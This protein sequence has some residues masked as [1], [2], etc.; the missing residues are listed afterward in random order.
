[1]NNWV[2]E[3]EFIDGTGKYFNSRK[4]ELLLSREG[5]SG[6]ITKAKLRMIDLPTLSIDLFCF[7]EP[8][9]LLGQVR[10]LRKDREVYFLEFID[11]RTAAELGMGQT[12]CLLAAYAGTKGKIR[13]LAEVKELLDKIDAIHSIIRR[14][15]YYYIEDPFV[16]LEKAYDLVEWCEKNNVF[17]HGHIGLGNFYAY[18][19]KNDSE[20]ISSFHSFV[21]RI[22]GC[23]GTV[24][25]IGS[26]HKEVVREETKKELFKI[27]DEYDYNNILNPGKIIDYR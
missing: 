17:L 7:K 19:K 27:K 23:F 10:T 9:E 16:S 12:Y 15:G 8:S 21:K 5:L 3:V 11:Q 4:K 22:G 26:V 20:L 6:L 13:N 1:M 2:E 25:G 18:F 14:K 24:F